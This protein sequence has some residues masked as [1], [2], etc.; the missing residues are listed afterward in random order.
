MNKQAHTA[1]QTMIRMLDGEIYR[2]EELELKVIE[3]GLDGI[4][5]FDFFDMATQSNRQ[6]RYIDVK[7]IT[8]LME[9]IK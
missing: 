4:R 9:I 7:S 8:P 2:A 1:G 5:V 3:G 6:V